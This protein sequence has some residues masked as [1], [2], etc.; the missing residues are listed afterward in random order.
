MRPFVR[1]PRTRV[2][3]LISAQPRRFAHS[4]YG[5]EQSGHEQGTHT[6]NPKQ[7]HEHPGPPA[8]DVGQSKGQSQ[9]QGQVDSQKSSKSESSSSSSPSSSA[10]SSGAKPTIQTPKSAAEDQDPEVKKHNEEMAQRADKSVNQ[11]SEDDNKVDKKF[12][13]GKLI[14]PQ[15]MY[16]LT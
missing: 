9:S 7:S 5:N 8:P 3:S 15:A 12:W 16:M 10:S 6:K 4:S 11:L 13:K 2:L 14:S 1:A